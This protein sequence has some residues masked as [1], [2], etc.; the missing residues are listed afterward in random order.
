GDKCEVRPTRDI[1]RCEIS[2]PEVEEQAKL[3]R[4]VT[5]CGYYQL[6]NPIFCCP[7][8]SINKQE[9]DRFDNDR[10]K[11]QPSYRPE[12]DRNNQPDADPLIFPDDPDIVGNNNIGISQQKCEEYSKQF[13]EVVQALPLVT[14]IKPIS[15]EIEKCDYN[16]VPLIVGGEPAAVGEFPFMA[17]IGFNTEDQKWKCGGTLI[18]DRFVLTAAHCTSTR[19]GPPTLIRLGDLDLST[20]SDGLEHQDYDIEKILRHPDYRYPLKYHDI[21]LIKTIQT[22]EFTKFIRPACLFTNKMI[23]QPS[24]VATGWGKTDF[25][26]ENSDKLMK[27]T[28]NIYNRDRCQKTYQNDKNLPRGIVSSM[29]CV[30]ELQGGKD[31]CQGDS[32]GP[33]LI[34][35]AGNQCK[36]YIIGVTSFGKSCGQVNT[37]AVYTKISS[38]IDWIERTIW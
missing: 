30:G 24:G 27:V 19:F 7:I 36:F 14:N 15:F 4:D 23:Q 2:C 8:D 17:A 21:A 28:L 3:G 9:I 25:A 34:T 11:P 31:T 16:S 10:F 35:E 37:P 5:L 12:V 18:S 32:G 26:A 22:V 1:G 6:V 38:Y 33:L 20:S 13:S 29:L